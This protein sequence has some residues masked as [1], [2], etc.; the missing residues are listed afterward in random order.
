MKG[1][2]VLAARQAIRTILSINGAMGEC[3]CQLLY[4]SITFVIQTVCPIDISERHASLGFVGLDCSTAQRMNVENCESFYAEVGRRVRE[5]R[6]RRK[7]RLT[8]QS[9]ADMVCLTRTSITN[10]E[11]GRQ[12]F[13]LHTLADI[14]KVLQVEAASLLPEAQADLDQQLSVA[15]KNRPRT[16][17][18]W[19]KSTISAAQKGRKDDGT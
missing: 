8:Q 12:K 18:E 6:L 9:L 13:L 14:A 11:K 7:P 4:H 5:A 19:I 3:Q 2:F 15:L 1:C 16:E 17:K 10:L